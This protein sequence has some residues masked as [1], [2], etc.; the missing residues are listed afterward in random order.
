MKG[1]LLC[2]GF[3]SRLLPMTLITNKHLL[4]VYDRPVI[5]YP[6]QTLVNSGIDEIMIVTGGESVGQFLELLGDG[7]HLGISQL[8]YTYQRE[9]GGIA[10]ALALSKDFAGDD[11]ICVCLGD[12]ITDADLSKYVSEFES[13]AKIFVKEVPDPERYGVVNLEGGRITVID[14]KPKRP[15]SN[16]AV[17]GIYMYDSSVWGIVETL[18]PSTRGELEITDVNNKYIEDGNMNWDVLPGWWIDC[19]TIDALY[20]ASTYMMLQRK[21]GRQEKIEWKY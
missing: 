19:G 6:I 7:K 18:K 11:D 14:E 16:L 13:G 10:H 3:G 12:N 2:G 5:Y 1:V 17:V 9:V 8:Q 20:E 15:K 21:Q 4:P